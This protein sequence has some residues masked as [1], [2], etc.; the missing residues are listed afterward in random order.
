MDIQWL[1]VIL[2]IGF[3]MIALV[4]LLVI[5]FLIY[6]A[7]ELRKASFIL[8]EF[9]RVTEEKVS[10]ILK[11]TEQTLKSLRRVSDEVGLITEDVRIRPVLGEAEQTLRSLKKVSDDVGMVTESARDISGAT[12]EI[13]IN[14]KAISSL[15]NTL[16][17]GVS[18]QVSGVK[19]GIKAALN[20]LIKQIKEGRV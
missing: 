8:K 16:G 18:L 15:T 5:G 6:A 1:I 10:P 11:E 12:R 3:F 4:F 13:V 7:I 2:S 20:N 9:S 19:A 17:G 14:L